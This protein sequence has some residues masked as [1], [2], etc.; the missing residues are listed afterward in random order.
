MENSD[1]KCGKCA[2]FHTFHSLYVWKVWNNYG[3]Y[4]FQQVFQLDLVFVLKLSF[5]Q[6]FSLFVNAAAV[7]LHDDRNLRRAEIEEM[8]AAKINFFFNQFRKFLVQTVNDTARKL[9]D[10]F[11]P[12][13]PVFF[14]KTFFIVTEFLVIV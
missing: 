7:F 2:F 6:G 9:I 5:Q 8:K 4:V 10:G 1:K 11:E 12:L 13:P 3:L 14:L